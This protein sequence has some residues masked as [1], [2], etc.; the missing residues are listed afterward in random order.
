MTPLGRLFGARSVAVVGASATPGKAGNALLASLE[1]FPGAV[2]AVNPRGEDVAGRAGVT[3]VSELPEPVDLALLAIPAAAVPAVAAECATAGIGAAVVHSGGWAEAGAEGAELQAALGA[4]VRESGLRVLGPNTSGFFSLRS[5]LCA[6]FVRT[7]ASLPAGGLAIVAQSGGVNHALAFLAAAEGLGI[8]LGVGLGNAVD[9]GFADVLDHLADD[10][11][12]EVVV[13]AVEGVAD[14]RRLVDAV[15]LLTESVPV[16]ALKAGRTDVDAFSRSHTGAL[17]GSWRVTRAALAQAGAVVV[18]DTTALIDAAQALGLVRLPPGSSPG[19]GVVTGQAGPGL[20]LADELGVQRVALPE[21]AAATTDRLRELLPPITFQRNPVDTG[22]P[23]ESFGDVLATVA[24]DPA[25]DLLTVYLLDEPD[26]ADVSGLLAAAP[27]PAV[28][29]LT[30]T[31]ERLTAVR[32]DLAGAVPVLPTPERAAR[33]VAALVRDAQLRSRRQDMPLQ[34]VSGACPRTR[35]EGQWDEDS[36]KRLVEE[37]GLRTPR[38][39]VCTTHHEART[40]LAELGP[41]VVVKV[42]H[43]GVLHKTDA[44]GVHLGV[45]DDLALQRAL[46]AIDRIAGGRYLVEEMAP[47]GPEL[48]LGARRDPVFGP[49]VALGLGGTGVEAGDD[50]TTR[51]APVPRAEAETMLDELASA[52]LFRGARGAPAVDEDELA[53]AIAAFGGLIAGRDDIAEIEVNPLRVT[54]GGLL[55][56]DALVVPA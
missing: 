2:Y 9:V 55:A 15:Q 47:P 51:I 43:P 38:R 22:R 14:G 56:L 30:A 50:A 19:V 25:V 44:G 49:L 48:I 7:A 11:A 6:S 3:R 23:A 37:L 52:P 1:S 42:L 12:V 17:T 13:L 46:D 34:G 26:A 33:A 45:A 18:E 24:G 53:A 31:P 5:S 21:L 40:A 41:P 4:V 20:L 32:A 35:P 28:L 39:R 10:G 54:A 29:A 16:V 27:R 36:A 8:H